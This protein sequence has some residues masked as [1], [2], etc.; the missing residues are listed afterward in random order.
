MPATATR[1][2]PRDVEL[3]RPALRTFFRIA[4][5]WSLGVGEQMKLLGL[6]SRST[7]FKWKREGTR[8]LP[9]DTLERLSYIFGIYK[10]LQILFPDAYAADQWVRRPNAAPLFG[11]RSALDR[12]LSGS[13]ADLYVVRRYLDAER[14][15]WP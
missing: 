9:P 10:D 15:G 4:E 12:M 14:G 7:Y 1:S 13:V 8:R 3:A 5:R 6:A 11:G 2:A